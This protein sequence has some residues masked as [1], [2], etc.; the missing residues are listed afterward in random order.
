MK[1]PRAL[2][3]RLFP[4]HASTGGDNQEI[5]RNPV[6]NQANS[7][8]ANRP[9][10]AGVVVNFPPQR[11]LSG[12]SEIELAEAFA[13]QQR[14][15]FRYHVGQRR[16]YRRDLSE[17]HDK[18]RWRRDVTLEVEFEIRRFLREIAA[19]APCVPG[20]ARLGS[21]SILFAVKSLARCALAGGD[22]DLE[23]GAS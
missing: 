21:R 22:D 1:K 12:W 13:E 2:P 5:S 9:P 20:N 19:Q 3:P 16:W 18:P 15:R 7:E 11:G 14:T 4:G 8:R 6:R 10:A 17:P 23:M